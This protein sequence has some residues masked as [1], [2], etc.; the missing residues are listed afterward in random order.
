MAESRLMLVMPRA[1]KEPHHLLRG[2]W[3]D[4]VL[5]GAL[6]MFP[7]VIFAGHGDIS[8]L[9]RYES[10]GISLP[11]LLWAAGLGLV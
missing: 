9:I 1:T 6:I 11:V 8:G 4:T 7:S 10:L 3:K 5:I 2:N